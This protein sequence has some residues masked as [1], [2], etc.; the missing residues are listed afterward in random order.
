MIGIV[1]YGMGNLLSVKNAFE[2]LGE[3]V[4][5]VSDPSTLDTVDK[6][7]LPGVGAFG[8][9]IKNLSDK[10]FSDALNYQVLQ[11]RKP[12]MG[13]CLGMQVMG[14]CGYE[15]GVHTGLGWFDADVVKLHPTDKSLRVPHVGWTDTTVKRDS[16]LFKGLSATP[17]F[18]FVHSF[19]VKCKNE[20]EVDAYYDYS[21]KVTASI[22]K[23][24]IFGTQFHPEK[25]Q[26]HGLR[27]LENFIKWNP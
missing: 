20:T 13:I 14:M 24:N 8:D 26:E 9:C 22:R 7:I 25:S 4:E 3:E 27:I 17:D 11:K 5:T 23:G 10:G 15:G 21:H 19:Y 2:Y 18:Y 16:P 6:I 1:D 12:I